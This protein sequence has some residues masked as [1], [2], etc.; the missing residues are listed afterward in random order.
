MIEPKAK[1]ILLIFVLSVLLSACNLSEGGNLPGNKTPTNPGVNDL[2]AGD[3]RVTL[4]RGR[5]V[6]ADTGVGLTS[7]LF[8]RDTSLY[9]TLGDFELA[10]PQGKNGYLIRGL[11]GEYH[12]EL[13]HD[14][15][16][17]H[18]LRVPAFHGWSE[19]YFDEL[20]IL[21]SANVTVRWPSETEIPVWVET[22]RQDSQVTSYSVT[23]VWDAFST[24]EEVL[25]KEIRFK[26]SSRSA[27]AKDGIIVEFISREDMTKRYDDANTI[28]LCELYYYPDRGEIVQGV[29][30]I[31]YDYQ[32]SLALH[33]H[34]VGHC[35]GLRHSPKRSDVMYPVHTSKSKQLSEEE[36]NMARLLYSIPMGTPPLV[37]TNRAV[38]P[39]YTNEEGLAREI[40]PMVLAP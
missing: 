18:R 5:V 1:N 24:W 37:S 22:P 36:K 16:A 38:V 11:L 10:I 15:E 39:P 4:I 30:Y 34:E 13:L 12:G 19:D 26:E 14:G 27:A 2:V 9:T 21:R 31:V 33:L 6:F 17:Y 7:W 28:G 35:I 25:N 29:I 23:T 40:I 20:L 3:G 32:D 8:F